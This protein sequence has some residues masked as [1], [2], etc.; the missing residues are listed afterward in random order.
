MIRGGAG[1]GGGVT[2]YSFTTFVSVCLSFLHDIVV[3]IITNDKKPMI[4]FIINKLS[5]NSILRAFLPLTEGPEMVI[6]LD[7][8]KTMPTLN[9]VLASRGF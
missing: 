6:D 8:L 9:T 5:D 3:T 2:I 7:R 1:G 4:F